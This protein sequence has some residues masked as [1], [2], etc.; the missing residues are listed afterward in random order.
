M[1]SEIVTMDWQACTTEHCSFS[2]TESTA[3]YSNSGK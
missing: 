2:R 3:E 1:F